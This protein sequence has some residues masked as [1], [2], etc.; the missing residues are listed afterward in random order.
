[1]S[2]TLW[3]K[4][5]LRTL[6]KIS[7]KK[8]L[9]HASSTWLLNRKTLCSLCSACGQRM[10]T[11]C[12]YSILVQIVTFQA[13]S[14]KANRVL[15]EN[16]VRCW[17]VFNVL[18]T[19]ISVIRRNSRV[20]IYWWAEI[21]S[22]RFWASSSDLVTASR[23]ESMSTWIKGRYELGVWRGIAQVKLPLMTLMWEV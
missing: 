2:L 18:W 6:R 13:F 21:S 23:C 8:I 11:S 1:M 9:I 22:K 12:P 5:F 3:C 19:A 10:A 17:L 16:S 4:I 7:S 15:P 14:K 20:S